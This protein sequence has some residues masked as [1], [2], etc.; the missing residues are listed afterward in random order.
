MNSHKHKHT[1]TCTP[2][3]NYATQTLGRMKWSLCIW[4]AG[5]ECILLYP[6]GMASSYTPINEQTHT[7]THTPCKKCHSH[8]S[9]GI[10]DYS[11]CARSQFGIYKFFISSSVC[12]CV[13][14]C[15]HASHF[16][17]SR[18]RAC[19]PVVVFENSCR[20]VDIP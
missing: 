9:F 15:A 14:T 18:R 20:C 4:H 3:N 11:V 19:T 17:L 1:R 13:C 5:S 10:H 6:S 12:E 8:T 16:A 7:H 2:I